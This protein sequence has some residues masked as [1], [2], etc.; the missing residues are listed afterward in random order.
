MIQPSAVRVNKPFSA[1]L[2]LCFCIFYTGSVF[3][4][5]SSVEVEEIEV[6]P[7]GSESTASALWKETKEKT[8]E[9]ANSAASFSKVQGTKI[10]EASKTGAAKGADA[11]A[12]GSV[13]AWEATKSA[14]KSATEYTG[15]KASQAG[16]IIAGAV[17]G[18]EKNPPVVDKSISE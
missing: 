17:K 18:S 12:K 13:K 11:V 10:L 6:A 5:S 8:G 9:A 15:E 16:S 7:N 1:L 14:T 2:I 4:Q 3:A